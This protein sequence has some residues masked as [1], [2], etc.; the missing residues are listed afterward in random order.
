MMGF[1]SGQLYLARSG[2]DR[3]LRLM[4]ESKN[5]QMVW[6]RS[7]SA[8]PVVF[9]SLEDFLRAV[10]LVNESPELL[11]VVEKHGEVS[12][13]IRKRFSEGGDVYERIQSS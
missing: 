3:K 1:V 5:R 4:G 13:E 12:E 10:A 2:E 8:V 11:S 7:L 9:E 6:R